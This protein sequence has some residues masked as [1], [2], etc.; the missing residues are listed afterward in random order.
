MI[1]YFAEVVA[2]IFLVSMALAVPLTA[3]GLGVQALVK[4]RRYRQG[5]R[6]TLLPP[7]GG[8]ILSIAGG[9]CGVA[10]NVYSEPSAVGP[11]AHNVRLKPSVQDSRSSF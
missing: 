3:V 1:R 9:P 4:S 2:L 7:A 6:G 8:A 11:Y 10:G 5:P